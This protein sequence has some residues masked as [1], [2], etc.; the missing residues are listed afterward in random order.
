ML[1][2][3]IISGSVFSG[4][5]TMLHILE[6]NKDIMINLIHDK[7]INALKYLYSLKE[8]KKENN[9]NK[10]IIFKKDNKKIELDEKNLNDSLKYTAFNTFLK[11]Y[12]DEGK[13]PNKFSNLKNEYYNF[14]FNFERF[15]K[16]F[17]YDI[18]DI[19]EKKEIFSEEFIDIFLL[20]F[21]K[22]KENKDIDQLKDKTYAFK[23][24]NDQAS[25]DFILSEDFNCKIIYVERNISGLI[26][27]R[28]QQYI[29]S[30]AKDK[31]LNIES[32]YNWIAN[33]YF[34]SQIKLEINK[35]KLNKKIFKNKILLTSLEKLVYDTKEEI[36]KIQEFLN[37]KKNI[38]IKNN[39]AHLEKIN[40][41]KIIIK[42]K[43]EMFVFYRYYGLKYILNNFKVKIF[44][45]YIFFNIKNSVLKFF[46]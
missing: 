19:K 25:V 42:E 21:F 45:R 35:I 13:F 14:N 28:A 31:A 46:N 9:K 6:N 32:V 38:S 29:I 16:N 1:K 33:S 30:H 43:N 26:K 37:L 27:S 36:K 2:K 40:D 22:E 5:Q 39:I 44:L 3:I 24:P 23:A 41:D 15:K 8:I 20:N 18:F 34:V 7:M 10:L 11:Q 12:S 17:L 4:K